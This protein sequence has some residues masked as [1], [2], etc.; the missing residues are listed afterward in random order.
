MKSIC[1]LILCLFATTAV[2]M[3]CKHCLQAAANVEERLSNTTVQLQIEEFINK[4]VCAH[5]HEVDKDVCIQVVEV[6]FP[7][8][9]TE[10]LNRDTPMDICVHFGYC[11]NTTEPRYY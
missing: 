4:T 8:I 11:Q 5:L 2:T 1:A 10:V 7:K 3:S 6:F 9:L